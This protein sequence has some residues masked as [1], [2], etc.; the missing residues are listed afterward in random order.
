M[1][2]KWVA[3]LILLSAANGLFAFESMGPST[4][5]HE[6]KQASIAIEYSWSEVDIQVDGFGIGSFIMKDAKMNKTHAKLSVSVTEDLELFFRSG[7]GDLKG[8]SGE[9]SDEGLLLGGGFKL[10]IVRGSAFDWGVMAQTGWGKFNFDP[11]VFEIEGI[12]VNLKEQVTFHEVQVA[13]G[14]VIPLM[15]NVVLYG[16]PFL[17]FITGT[18][19]VQGSFGGSSIDEDIDLNEDKVFGGYIGT[20]IQ[21]NKETNLIVE[22]QATGS[23]KGIAASL[24][25]KF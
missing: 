18:D 10:A 6:G 19:A 3:A 15:E 4:P 11:Q 12:P 17:H 14:P 20:L 8:E 7:I 13:T 25:Y 5:T 9:R 2:I 24:Q 22:F 16:G 21:L 1:K 23:G